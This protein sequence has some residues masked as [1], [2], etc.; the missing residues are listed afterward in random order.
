QLDVL[1]DTGRRLLDAEALAGAGGLD[2][3]IKSVDQ[4]PRVQFDGIEI[5]GILERQSGMRHGDF[6]LRERRWEEPLL[7]RRRLETLHDVA[8]VGLDRVGL[9]P[10]N[11]AV[12]EASTQENRPERYECNRSH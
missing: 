11:P 5:V 12:G 1:S 10:H 3:G 4:M 9:T 7:V 6:R 2:T 8:D